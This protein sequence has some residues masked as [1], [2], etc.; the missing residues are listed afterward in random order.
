MKALNFDDLCLE[1]AKHFAP[2]SA[3]HEQRKMAQAVQDFV[4]DYVAT[5]EAAGETP[6]R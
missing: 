2:T 1:V 4:E 5:L 3:E 6:C